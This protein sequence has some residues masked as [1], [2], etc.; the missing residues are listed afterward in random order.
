MKLDLDDFELQVPLCRRHALELWQ[1][2]LI[3]LEHFREDLPA[4]L[5]FFRGGQGPLFSCSQGAEFEDRD[6]I[7]LVGHVANVQSRN[8]PTSTPVFELN[9]G[10]R[11]RFDGTGQAG[12]LLLRMV[13]VGHFILGAGPRADGEN[14]ADRRGGKESAAYHDER[15]SFPSFSREPPASALS[16]KRPIISYRYLAFSF[17]Y[18]AFRA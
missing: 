8:V 14:H 10:D 1:H 3:A 17:S 18:C 7:V 16:S 6:L 13:V 12:F 5:H 4:C 9:A 11:L 15:T 2:L